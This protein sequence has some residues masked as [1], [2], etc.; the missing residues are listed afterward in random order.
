MKKEIVFIM[1]YPWFSLYQRPNHF[2]RLFKR[3]GYGVQVIEFRQIIRLNSILNWLV[4]ARRLVSILSRSASLI[5][6]L[7][8]YWSAARTVRIN[9]RAK[10]ITNGVRLRL[11]EIFIEAIIGAAQKIETL[12]LRP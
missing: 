4:D 5:C 6:P 3:N 1:S 9:T 11:F 12:D 7:H 2:A 10:T 8:R